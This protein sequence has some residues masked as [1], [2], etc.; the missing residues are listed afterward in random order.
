MNRSTGLIVALVA[1]GIAGIVITRQFLTNYAMQVE[2]AS[3]RSKLDAAA[4]APPPS[5]PAAVAAVPVGPGGR[6]VI[7][8]A[9]QIMTDVLAEESGD[10]K[11]LWLR[12]DPRD[13]EAS[14]FAGQIGDVFREAGWDVKIQDNEGLRYKPGLLYLVGVEEDPPSYVVTAHRAI[15]SIGYE[16]TSGRGYLSYYESKKKDDPT[17]QGTTFQPGQTAVLLVGRKPEPAT[18]AAAQ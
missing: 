8:S 3:M 9:R 14:A 10:E 6:A 18:A 2:L 13:R 5:A 11:K 1:L 17:W 12:V 16:L 15:E 7:E 4:K